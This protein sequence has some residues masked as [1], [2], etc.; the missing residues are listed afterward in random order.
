MLST[1]HLK[2]LTASAVCACAVFGAT[3]IPSSS[4][5][6]SGQISANQS[7]E[8]TLQQQIN[9]ESAQ[10][11]K[12][13]GGVAAARESLDAVQTKLDNSVAQLKSVQV[14]LFD[15]R[16]QVLT[17]E[18]RLRVASNDLASNLRASYENGAPNLVDVI[19]SSNG[20]NNLLSQVDFIK[21]IETQDASIVSWTKS[22]RLRVMHEADSLGNLEERD[23]TLTDDILSQRNQEAALEG[24]L[25]QQ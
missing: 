8:Q 22:A 3:Q 2:R 23:R 9:A 21:R 14:R 25:L 15:A 24:A 12:T 10:I 5:D 7:A 11:Q 13:A 17:L 1:R 16:N 6:L 18:H 20:F 4:A 19:L